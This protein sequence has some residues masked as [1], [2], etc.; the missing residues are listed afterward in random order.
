MKQAKSDEEIVR[1]YTIAEALKPKKVSSKSS[2]S[3]QLR[4][5][6]DNYHREQ[7]A[8]AEQPIEDPKE[9]AVRVVD[10]YLE[11]GLEKIRGEQQLGDVE[12]RILQCPKCGATTGAT[13]NCQVDYKWVS[14]GERARKAIETNPEKSDREIAEAVGVSRETIRRARVEAAQV[15]PSGGANEPRLE[16]EANN[17]R[18]L[19]PSGDTNVSRSQVETGDPAQPERSGDTNVSRLQVET[20]ETGQSEPAERVGRDGKSYPVPTPKPK[21]QEKQPTVASLKYKIETLVNEKAELKTRHEREIAELKAGYERKIAELEA[22]YEALIQEYKQ[23]F[24][25]LIKITDV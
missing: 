20:C 19:E 24:D 6:L 18:Q 14:P 22:R 16:V 13:C 2:Y 11:K 4:M 10:T 25:D 9:E 1:P 7:A 8:K 23:C 5:L 12:N 17:L 3:P 21:V 15:K